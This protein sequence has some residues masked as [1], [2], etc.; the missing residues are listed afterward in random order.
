M[1]H[2]LADAQN[3]E[4][5]DNNA[6]APQAV[7]ADLLLAQNPLALGLALRLASLILIAAR[8]ASLVTLGDHSSRTTH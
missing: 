2:Q 8:I 6:A 1:N 5:Q 7:F 3:E 4:Q